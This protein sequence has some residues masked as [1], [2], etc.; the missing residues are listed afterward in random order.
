MAP[1]RIGKYACL[2]IERRFL[3]REIPQGL[4]DQTTGWRIIDRYITGTRL[5]VR[6]MEALNGE[7]VVYK[8]GQKYRSSSQ[9]P[10]ETTMTTIYL[11]EFDYGRLM[12]LDG[13][14]L[15]KTRFPFEINGLTFGIDRFEASLEGLVLAEIECRTLQEF[16]NLPAPAVEWVDVTEDVFFTGGSLVKLT[17]EQ[18]SEK[19]R[20]WSKPAGTS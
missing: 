12:E 18:F 20:L 3:L 9:G 1:E 6:R 19:M 13:R 5:R 7:S 2:E 8:L 16:K 14:E 11:D 10:G 4:V 17:R 15:R